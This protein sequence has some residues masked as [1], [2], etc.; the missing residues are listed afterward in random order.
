[1]TSSLDEAVDFGVRRPREARSAN[2]AA[3]LRYLLAHGPTSR[4]DLAA[5]IGLTQGPVTRIVALLLEL[6]L[7]REESAQPLA[8]GRGRPPV[9]VAI[10]PDA[11]HFISA[12]VGL[13][14]VTV[15][16]VDLAGTVLQERRAEHGGHP[17]AIAE[18]VSDLVAALREI[19]PSPVL[20]VGAVVGGWVDAEAGVVRRHDGLGWHDVPVGALL[21]EKLGEEVCVES[22]VRSHALADMIYGLMPGRSDFV[23]IFIGN[24][25]EVAS[26]I[27][28]RVLRGLDGFGGD[29]SSW[30][31]TD[32][33]GHAARAADLLSDYVVRA[34]A[35]R[36]GL[37]PEDCTFEELVEL[38]QS[39]ARVSGRLNDLLA[40]RARRAAPLIAGVASMMAPSA[41]VVS[42]GVVATPPAVAAL[43]SEYRR[44]M[45]GRPRPALRVLP[46]YRTALAIAGAAVALERV[47]LADPLFTARA[48]AR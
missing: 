30:L 48:P 14:Q 34:S 5:G 20:G 43:E 15:A 28:G 21:S 11:W 3:V 7:V 27:D 25:I 19:H 47:L 8:T 44:L 36:E 12:H 40:D 46:H 4:V 29:L 32:D 37:I 41:V 1:M 10:V 33:D 23:H 42:S 31:L 24:V 2:A 9:P 22:A 38:A 18:Q 35:Q 13:T 45:E 6:G 39:D 16:R 17:A 26:V